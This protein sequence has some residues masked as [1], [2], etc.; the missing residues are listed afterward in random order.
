MLKVNRFYMEKIT[1]H[2]NRLS[3]DVDVYKIG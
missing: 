3:V 2:D 1:M